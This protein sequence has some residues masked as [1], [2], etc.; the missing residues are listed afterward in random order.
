MTGTARTATA[1]STT[2]RSAAGTTTPGPAE[3]VAALL[4]H[5]ADRP[6]LGDRERI[7]HT[8]P[9]TG[10]QHVTLQ[11]R[12][13]TV[14]FREL[15]ERITSLA[16][17]WSA[18]PALQPGDMVA[19]IGFA[20][21]DYTVID[22]AITHLGAVSVPL[23]ADA[24]VPQLAAI[25]AETE[26]R[27]LATSINNLGKAA[28]LA[29]ATP[30]IEQVIIFDVLPGLASHEQSIARLRADGTINVL[31][32]TD[33]IARGAERPKP[34]PFRP[35]PGEEPLALLIYT[36]GSTGTPKGAMYTTRMLAHLWAEPDDEDSDPAPPAYLHY[37]PMS[38]VYGRMWLL[39]GLALGGT[40]FFAAAPDMSTLFEDLALVR[41]TAVNLVPRVAELLHQR[42][43]A[44]A[45]RAGITSTDAFEVND[46]L[47]TATRQA[48]LGDRLQHAV[49]GSAPLTPELR[50]FLKGFLAVPLRDGY[51]STETSGGVVTNTVVMRPPVLDYKLV[52]APELGY[53]TTDEPHP[54]G[55]LLIKATTVFPGYYRRPDATAQVFDED[56]FYRTGDIVAEIAPDRLVYVDRRNN[57]LKLAQGEFVAIA[58][59]EALYSASPLIDQVFLYGN[60]ARSYLLAVVEPSEQARARP[61][62]IPETLRAAFEEVAE[63]HELA[64]YEVP[65]EI[66]LADEPFTTANGLLTGIGKLARPRLAE[67]Y[68]PR[69]ED[70]YVQLDT[71]EIDQV[72]S[73]R[74][75][76]DHRPVVE[77]LL[78]LVQARIGSAE[79][80]VPFTDLGGDSL[81]AMSVATGIEEIYDLAIAVHE[82]ISP[83]A[84][85]AS[86]A[87]RIEQQR[88]TAPGD[89]VFS[90]I[91]GHRPAVT[92]ASDIQLAKLLD[93]TTLRSATDLPLATG[94]P[95][96]VLLTGA[97]GYLGRFVCLEYLEQLATTGGT[98]ICLVR[99]RDETD[100][101]A[102]LDAAFD[103]G[104]PELLA[105]YQE[106]ATDHLEVIAGDAAAPRFGL[107][108]HQWLDL[109]R[110]TDLIVHV[111]ALV[112]HVLPYPELF[113]PNVIGTA[114][115]IE[116]A[117]TTTRKPVHFLSTVAVTLLDDGSR[118]AEDSD[119]REASP[120][121]AVSDGYA[122]GYATSK[123]ASEVLL[124]EAHE[125]LGIP[126]TVFRSGMILAHSRYTGQLNV[127]DNFTRLL[128]SVLAT[129]L[130]PG[131]FYRRGPAAQRAH[132]D[133][134]PVDFTAAAVRRL[135]QAA[136]D[137]YR[138]FN[139]L[140]THDDGISL[141]T[142]IDWL[143]EDGHPITRID[144]H[145]AWVAR[146]SAAMEALPEQQRQHTVLPLM[147]AYQRPATSHAEDPVLTARF[148]EAIAQH[149]VAGQHA[150]PSLDHALISK[151]ARDL[152][153]LGLLRMP[154]R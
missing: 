40:G 126:V 25:L 44:A 136:G 103:S 114:R 125:H 47:A 94:E 150:V 5:H 18:T 21:I 64:A 98:L 23:Q 37:M 147:H 19:V 50:R 22:L 42:Y 75:Q 46:A 124:R 62:A 139:V 130:A 59:L 51:G 11:P 82:I 3:T 80:D 16:A 133:G 60:S 78:D 118:L 151:Y 69:L 101:R 85:L 99:G 29:R 153:A 79:A 102:R 32:L 33:A 70:L 10:E 63:R 86:L 12:F 2:A 57:V 138:T 142:F 88:T 76:R 141:D 4:H 135:G 14:T 38:H 154:A 8:D 104:D 87:A 95:R 20:S 127:P 27:I 31:A 113:E 28:E 146:I 1:T 129:G 6:A 152:A 145:R 81:A 128:L 77:V 91:H 109:A 24:P 100:A 140:S 52:D 120:A 96:T 93:A 53:L 132:Y 117:A 90:A 68:G 84:T 123:W 41:P 131:S 30:S 73:L 39:R 107:A 58:R 89:S 65:R 110:R 9:T 34:P 35:A 43:R 36:S 134:I 15:A 56:G 97:T 119:I 106:L 48:M 115:V 67:L 55:E 45:R 121:R 149:G 74:E 148:R 61:G 122:N 111:A 54:R 7:A 26:P 13:T 49:V 83:T 105:H 108:S 143:I 71:T 92:R 17:H 137:S 112:N 72:A 116:L 66:V 144:D